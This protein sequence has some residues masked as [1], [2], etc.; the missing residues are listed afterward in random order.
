MSVLLLVWFADSTEVVVTKLVVAT[1]IMWQSSVALDA[2][3]PAVLSEARGV[4]HDPALPLA[5]IG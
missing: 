2:G 1:R 3:Q 5:D 4:L